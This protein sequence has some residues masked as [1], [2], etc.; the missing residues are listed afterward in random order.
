MHKLI[1]EIIRNLPRKQFD[2]QQFKDK[3]PLSFSKPAVPRAS[4]PVNP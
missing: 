2:D 3:M 1:G 4:I